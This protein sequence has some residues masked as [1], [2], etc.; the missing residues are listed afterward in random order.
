MNS[1]R[2]ISPHAYINHLDGFQK[3]HLRRL[4][5]EAYLKTPFK[6]STFGLE[7]SKVN[8]QELFAQAR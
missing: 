8:H 2:I 7:V 1:W 5:I 6:M 4:S 3:V